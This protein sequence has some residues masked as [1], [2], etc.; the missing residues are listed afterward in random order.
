M[1]YTAAYQQVNKL[2]GHLWINQPRFANV[3]LS[4]DLASVFSG[5]QN[6]SKRG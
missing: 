6:V 3:E 1:I 5:G 2:H 4:Q